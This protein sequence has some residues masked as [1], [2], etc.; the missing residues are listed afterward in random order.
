MD[1]SVRMARHQTGRAAAARAAALSERVRAG[2]RR[3]DEGVVTI[4]TPQVF[5][6]ER[7]VAEVVADAGGSG[8]VEQAVARVA[9]SA[10]VI[11]ALQLCVSFLDEQHPQP[12][13]EAR[14]EGVCGGG[15]ES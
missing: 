5:E 12:A 14:G 9:E 4:P 13:R 8:E 7:G 15:V 6:S 1:N 10:V 2:C 3:T 11:R